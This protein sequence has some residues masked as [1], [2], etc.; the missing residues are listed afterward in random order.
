MNDTPDDPQGLSQ[1]EYNEAVG[2][3]G[4]DGQFREPAPEWNAGW[5]SGALVPL[6]QPD[7]YNEDPEVTGAI[8]GGLDLVRWVVLA[9]IGEDRHRDG[10]LT[11][12]AAIAR[13]MRLYATDAEAAKAIGVNRS[14]LC[15]AISDMKEEIQRNKAHS[16]V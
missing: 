10:A 14:T 3:D 16:C 11:R 8:N 9:I 12:A 1:G 4:D 7:V 6:T 13:I 5:E 15:R 2:E